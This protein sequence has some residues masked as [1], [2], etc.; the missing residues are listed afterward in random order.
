MAPIPRIYRDNWLILYRINR[1]SYR[2]LLSTA[3]TIIEMD[4]Q[5]HHVEAYLGDMGSKCN[6]RLLEKKGTNL[7]VWNGEVSAAGA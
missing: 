6:T 4:E 3:E 5:M 2:G 1:V 7:R